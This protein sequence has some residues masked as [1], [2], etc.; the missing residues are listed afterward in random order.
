MRIY[1]RRDSR[2][3]RLWE[4]DNMAEIKAAPQ[5][6]RGMWR[7]GAY[8][9]VVTSAGNLAMDVDLVRSVIG[10]MDDP[11]VV[12]NRRDVR[13]MCYLD[14]HDAILMRLR[15]LVSK[16]LDTRDPSMWLMVRDLLISSTLLTMMPEFDG[17]RGL[18]VYEL[19]SSA[20]TL[21]DVCLRLA[22]A[23][24]SATAIVSDEQ[25]ALKRIGPLVVDI[26]CGR[27][28]AWLAYV[29]DIG[30]EAAGLQGKDWIVLRD[31]AAAQRSNERFRRVAEALGE[32][33]V[34]AKRVYCQTLMD[35]AG[36]F[37]DRQ[38]SVMRADTEQYV[39]DLDSSALAEAIDV[40]VFNDVKDLLVM[41]K[42]SVSDLRG[43]CRTFVMSPEA[44]VFNLGL[45]FEI[46]MRK[47]R[48]R[49]KARRTLKKL[50]RERT[51]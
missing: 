26:V 44:C 9:A 37:D 5:Q 39:F 1:A 28:G 41:P 25:L 2:R 13:L 35:I 16:P 22:S 38:W 51:E 32:T 10:R 8:R 50:E 45:A 18:S 20:C 43:Y 24:E 19:V 12:L 33:G 17:E 7:Y 42:P 49:D 40:A 15:D 46:E 47:M 23:E 29:D 4:V 31:G 48:M 27:V 34:E 6:L 14:A 30:C 21:V 36:D 3:A 11:E